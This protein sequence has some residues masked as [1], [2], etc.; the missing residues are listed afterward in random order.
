LYPYSSYIVCIYMNLSL[1][2]ILCDEKT[3]KEG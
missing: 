1:S 2:Q 3:V